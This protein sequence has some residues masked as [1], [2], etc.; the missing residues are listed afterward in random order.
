MTNTIRHSTN[1]RSEMEV[2]PHRQTV[3]AIGCLSVASLL[4]ASQKFDPQ[5][6]GQGMLVDCP[7]HFVH[8]FSGGELSTGDSKDCQ[9]V[10]QFIQIFRIGLGMDPKNSRNFPLSQFLGHGL[11]GQEHKFL[12]QLMTL[13]ILH[14]QNPVRFSFRIHQDLYVGRLEIQGTGL[15]PG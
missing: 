1:G 10:S 12:N 3:M 4:H 9:K 6:L 2:I 5:D 14:L 15:H 13:V 11:V 7:Q 8:L